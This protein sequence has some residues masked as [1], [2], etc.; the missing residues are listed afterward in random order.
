MTDLSGQ[1]LGRYHL[2]E[3]LGEGGMAIV[4]KAYD[5]RLER[6]VAVKIIRSGAFPVDELGGVLK[7]FEREAKSL[8]KLSHPNIVKVY[9]YGEHE[10][11]PYLVMEYLPGGTLKKFIGQRIPWQEALRL[12]FPIAR[13]VAY[14]HQR[15]ILHRDIKPA[16]I[17]ITE[18]G[19]PMLSD[20]GIAK[21]FEAEQTTVLTGS[22]MAIGTPEYMAPEQWTGI[23]SPQS[24]QYSLGIVLYE[25]VAGRKPYVADT[26]AAILIK[27][28]TERLP[29]PRT[30]AVDL[31]E[32]LERI[33]IKALAKEPGDRYEDVSAFISALEDLHMS[34]PV[35]P[36]EQEHIEE[37]YEI[38]S[39]KPMAPVSTEIST[40]IMPETLHAVDVV[41]SPKVEEP[42]SAKVSVAPVPSSKKFSLAGKRLWISGVAILLAIGLGTPFIGRWFS[43]RLVEAEQATAILAL[44][45]SPGA[46]LQS[47]E[48]IRVSETATLTVTPAETSTPTLLPLQT[49]LTDSHGVQ[50]VLVPEGDFLMGANYEQA[51]PNELP[52]HRVF[53][54]AYYM[55]K[56]EVTNALYKECVDAGVCD[57]PVN[58]TKYNTAQYAQHPVTWVYWSMAKEYCE[59]RGSRLP[60]EAEWEKAAR[61][62]DRRI[63]PWGN[64]I[65]KTY[66]NFDNA[67]GDTTPVGNYPKGVSRYGLYDMAGNVEEWVADWYGESYYAISPDSNPTGPETGDYHILRGGSWRSGKYQITSSARDAYLPMFSENYY[68]GFRCAKDANP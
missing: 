54:N 32:R 50:M 26:P 62:T 21:L 31:P 63:Y 43:S 41:E 6:D 52:L 37:N 15:G 35:I 34:M 24:D 48:T 55:D 20:F 14:A 36:A 13:G 23:T 46:E 38:A 45:I 56:Y 61:G 39:Q 12:L 3:Q 27:Q 9:D 53:L 18:S 44:T 60:A 25:M 66:A 33:L 59:W 17:L 30:F 4:Y 22:G 5:T 10:R 64:G 11:S 2:L 51:Q 19:E 49:E 29:S 68:P 40:Q 58:V 57:R 65:D 8:A 16:N 28:A 42:L 47:L 7:R 67:I 1:Y